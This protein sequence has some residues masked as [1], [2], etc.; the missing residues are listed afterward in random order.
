MHFRSVI[1][2]LL[3]PLSLLAQEP[4]APV[5]PTAESTATVATNKKT[6]KNASDKKVFS[7]FSGGMM[8][9]IG[10][11]FAQSPDE[12]FRNSSLINAQNLSRD[13]VTIGLGGAL[14]LHLFDHMH[15][16]G[17]GFVSTM[18]LMSSGSNIRTSWGGAMIDGYFTIGKFSPLLGVT[19]G[20]GSTKRI[21]VPSQTTKAR[22]EDD[23][24]TIYNASFTKTPF[25]LLDPYVGFEVALNSHVHLLF[26]VDYLLPFGNKNSGIGETLHWS[27]FISPSGPRLHIG[28]MFGR[29]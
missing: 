6:P 21:Y 27:S 3:L 2:A 19:I 11:A 4:A 25:F 17:E 22:T 20:G 29:P 10:Y 8:L 28:A 5:P 7:G 13:G 26:K 18:P 24:E 9:H 14:R 15:I 12:L 23:K 16:G 1:V